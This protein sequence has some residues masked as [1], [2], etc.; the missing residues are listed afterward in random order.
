MR[1]SV[2]IPRLELLVEREAGRPSERLVVLDSDLCRL[3]SH[4]GNDLVLADSLVSRFHCALRRGISG[5]SLED[6]GSLNG[7]RVSGVRV[8]SADLPLPECR[9][10]FGDSR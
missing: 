8:R 3:G 2:S 7:T 9:L 5:W 10:E 4:P 1:D 6:T